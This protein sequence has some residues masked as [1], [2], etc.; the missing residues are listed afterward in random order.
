MRQITYKKAGVDIA[1][2]EVFKARLKGLTRKSFTKG[3]IKDIGGFGAFFEI[4]KDEFKEPV[5]VSSCDGVGTKL[6]VAILNNCHDTVGID[7][8]AMNVNDILCAGAKA[9]FFLDYIAYSKL[10]QLTLL[11]IVKGINAGCLDAGCALIGGETAQ[12]PDMYKK[13]DYDLAGFCVG[14]VEKSKIIDGKNIEIGDVIIGLESNGIHANGFSLA[15]KVLSQNELK[16]MRDELLKPTRIYVKPVLNLL[17]ATGH[18]LQAKIKGIAHITGGAFYDKIARIL[19]DY[20]DAKI[21][22]SSWTVP[23]IFRLIQ[24]KGNIEDREMY[25]TFNMGIGMVLIVEADSAQKI[26]S[27][28]SK[29]KLKSW[30]IGKVVKGNKQVEIV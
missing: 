16:R 30:I 12:M 19:P 6:K 11:D 25:H 28:L 8:V 1:K 23:K 21:H 10:D 24:V 7:C 18:K 2:A 15:R 20:V 26:I 14:V 5:F 9:L 27:E 29:F 13:G 4:P 17:Q 3:A 22:K